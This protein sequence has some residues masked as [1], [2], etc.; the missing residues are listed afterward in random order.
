MPDQSFYQGVHPMLPTAFTS[1]GDFDPDSQRRL[2]EFMVEVGVRGVAILGFL[3]ESHKLSGVERRQVV[4][5]V[6][7]AAAGRIKVL[8]G[9]RALGTAGAI[10]QAVE[11]RELGADAVFAAPLAVQ[12]DTVLY[13]YYR[14]LA[15]LSRIPVMIHDFPDSFGTII[16]AS[17]ITRLANSVKGIV[18]IKSEE[19]PVLV[20][21]SHILEEAP[22]FEVLGGLG[23]VYFL[24]ELQ[25][26]AVGIMSGFA[27]PEV[28]VKIFDLFQA[29]QE[30]AAA[31][32]FDKYVPLIRY[33]FQPKI[34]VAFRKY[35][36]MKRGI[37]ESDY[38]RTPGMKL[39]SRSQREFE[40]IVARVGLSFDVPLE[41]A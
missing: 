36:Y 14:D 17:L 1:D 26:G 38:I 37:F 28:L 10:E 21:L 18:G 5:A 29:G 39:D 3:G 4:E 8:V 40:Q 30:Q 6:T 19:P 22:H 20:K 9:V 11:A 33:E 7:K 31:A 27:F 35:S 2:V 16:S 41:V 32:T 24:E 34:G 13:D 12:N 23:G 25:R 15:T